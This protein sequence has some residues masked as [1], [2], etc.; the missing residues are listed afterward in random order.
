LA[1]TYYITYP[2]AQKLIS[3]FRYMKEKAPFK[4]ARESSKRILHDL[5]FVKNQSYEPVGGYQLMLE[6]RDAE[7]FEN[8]RNAMED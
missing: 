7:F 6:E 4:D 1:K 8:T 3:A 2:E 5:S